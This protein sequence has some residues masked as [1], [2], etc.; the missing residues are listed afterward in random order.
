MSLTLQGHP[1]QS[2]TLNVGA[3]GPWFGEATL[4]QAPLSLVFAGDRI[5]VRIGDAALQATAIEITRVGGSLGVRFVGGA[6]GWSRWMKPR[7][8]H[9]DAGIKAR[10]LAED[11]ARGAGETL[12]TF[13]PARE[14]V[15][16]DFT[17]R[18]TFTAATA[19]ELAAGDVPWWVDYAGITHV[20]T[21]AASTVPPSAYALVSARPESRL[22][23]L[24][25]N[26]FAELVPGRSI[27]DPM[28]A[29]PL[30]IGDV[31]LVSINGQP[32][33]ATVWGAPTTGTRSRLSGL[34]NALIQRHTAPKLHGVYRY[35]VVGTRSDLRV[36]LQAVRAASGLPDAQAVQQCPGI[37]GLAANLTDGAEVLVMFVDGEPNEPLI[38]HYAGPGTNGF[39][40]VGLVLGGEDGPPA[41]RQGDPV[42]VLL[43]P[44]SFVGTVGP[45]PASGVIT[46]LNP[47]ADGAI[48]GGSGKVRIAT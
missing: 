4:S 23:T 16:V 30:V 32:L 3:I 15:G 26:A 45:A 47:T 44:A 18:G 43:P 29:E 2:I 48:M 20:G 42:R 1:V 36:D 10:E 38:T 41:A 39:V 25:V 13:E 11:A 5:T 9:N 19:L 27:V 33:R 12:G 8:Y 21:R 22:A 28:L 14:R 17:T 6:G 46:F 37:P 31:E 24:A 34:V 7:S 35:R 40:P